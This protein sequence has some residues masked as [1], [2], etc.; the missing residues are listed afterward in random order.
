LVGFSV[1]NF[2]GLEGLLLRVLFGEHSGHNKTNTISKHNFKTQFQNTIFKFQKANPQESNFKTQ[3]NKYFKTQF[4]NTRKQTLKRAI[5]KHNKTNI[6]KHK[7]K[8]QKTNIFKN[9]A[10]R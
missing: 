2:E 8:A 9:I 7:F 1:V 6:S 10:G 5:S 4:Q 3:E